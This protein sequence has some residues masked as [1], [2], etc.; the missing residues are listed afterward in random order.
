MGRAGFEPA[1]RFRGPNLQSGAINHSATYP[2]TEKPRFYAG[3]RAIEAADP[4]SNR[5]WDARRDARR[6]SASRAALGISSGRPVLGPLAL[7][8]PD[9][10]IASENLLL[11]RDPLR[12][13]IVTKNRKK[14]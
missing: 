3:F 6:I 13:L 7:R 4:P 5:R 12:H 10:R 8:L 11:N 2:C 14:P 9:S 1:Y